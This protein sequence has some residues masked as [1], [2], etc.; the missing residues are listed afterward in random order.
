MPYLTEHINRQASAHLAQ[1]A[2]TFGEVWH[3][4]ERQTLQA[5][6][7]AADEEGRIDVVRFAE[8]DIVIQKELIRM[9]IQKKSGRLKD[10]TQRHIEAVRGLA[11]K[12]A[13]RCVSLPYGLM[14]Y[15]RRCV[16]SHRGKMRIR[17]RKHSSGSICQKKR[18]G[19]YCSR[20]ISD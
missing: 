18:C 11:S 3:Y 4:I 2:E 14:C 5:W 13:G 1:A 12:P 7:D 6:K 9:L 10:I 15:P 16:F 20:R 17:C 8:E 19:F